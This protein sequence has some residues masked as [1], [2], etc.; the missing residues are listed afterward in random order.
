[1]LENAKEIKPYTRYQTA[2]KLLG[3]HPAFTQI[4]SDAQREQYFDEYVSG[5]QRRE[6][7]RLRELR[8]ASMEA[9]AHLLSSIP[10]IKFDTTWKK[11]QSIYMSHPDFERPGAF[12]GMDMLDFL[13]VYEDH[14]RVMW[15]EPE[16]QMEKMVR[17]QRRNARKA[18]DGFK[19][20]NLDRLDIVSTRANG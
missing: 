9:F 6:K 20:K 10:E 5:L 2:V 13:S 17:A 18:R 12:E 1:M 3:N 15:Q 16:A 7:D 19:V 14:M 4:K 8:K 11:A